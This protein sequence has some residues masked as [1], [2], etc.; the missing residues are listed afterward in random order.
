MQNNVNCHLKS[1]AAQ[2]HLPSHLCSLLWSTLAPQK[3]QANSQ[4]PPISS[5]LWA[6]FATSL[7][8]SY[9]EWARCWP[10]ALK[11]LLIDGRGWQ[12]WTHHPVT[13]SPRA[14]GTH[15]PYL[16][17]IALI[18]QVRQIK[19]PSFYLE[20]IPGKT[21]N[22]I[23]NWGRSWSPPC[24]WNAIHVQPAIKQYTEVDKRALF[25]SGM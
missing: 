23:I 6:G 9:L 15:W 11:L 8:P 10:C 25:I 24:I 2:P 20:C 12:C 19:E 21:S 13:T 17:F 3:D 4:P 1:L 22:Q 14:A 18:S 16:G 7:H 5:S